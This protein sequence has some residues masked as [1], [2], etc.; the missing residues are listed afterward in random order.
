MSNSGQSNAFE[1]RDAYYAALH[2]DVMVYE[3]L[4]DML[5][6]LA[7]PSQGLR[8]LCHDELGRMFEFTCNVRPRSSQLNAECASSSIS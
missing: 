2:R 3:A 1:L 7:L 4:D 8:S 6:Y 5:S